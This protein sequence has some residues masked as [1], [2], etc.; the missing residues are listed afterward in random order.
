LLIVLA[1]AESGPPSRQN[2][3]FGL[4]ECSFRT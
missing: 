4:A 1:L 3:R 2:A